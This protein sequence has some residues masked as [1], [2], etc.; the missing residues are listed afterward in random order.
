[1]RINEDI[2]TAVQSRRREI[3][4]GGGSYFQVLE[5]SKVN[6]A[7]KQM[8]QLEVTGFSAVN[9]RVVGEKRERRC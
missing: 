3:K 6:K 2:Y 1:M 4:G 9:I 5:G 7:E 8:A